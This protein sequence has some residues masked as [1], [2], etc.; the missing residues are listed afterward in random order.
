MMTASTNKVHNMA[1]LPPADKSN[2]WLLI[3]RLLHRV[4]KKSQ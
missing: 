1:T 4:Q 2:S 3:V